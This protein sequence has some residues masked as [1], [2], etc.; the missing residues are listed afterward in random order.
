MTTL[1]T[2]TVE[3]LGWV[4]GKASEFGASAIGV[5]TATVG[6]AIVLG[7]TVEGLGGS[8]TVANVTI[9]MIGLGSSGSD[10]GACATATGIVGTTTVPISGMLTTGLSDVA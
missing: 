1:G 5:F 7:T 10:A 4:G 2:S 3:T 9:G 6:S 8:D